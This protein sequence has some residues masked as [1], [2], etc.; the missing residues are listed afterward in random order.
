MQHK[1]LWYKQ[2][3]CRTHFLGT[4]TKRPLLTSVGTFQIEL[5][6]DALVFKKRGNRSTKR[7][8]HGGKKVQVLQCSHH[9]VKF[10][11]PCH[12]Y[13]YLEITSLLGRQRWNKF[14]FT[15]F[16]SH[17]VEPQT[18]NFRAIF[19]SCWEML[20]FFQSSCLFRFLIQSTPSKTDT[21]GTGS[22]CPS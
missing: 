21:F 14:K 20:I 11:N 13:Q 15:P 8:P 18:E 9:F 2:N 10:C 17:I 5:E 12:E 1:P 19:W 16:L 6:F 3:V 7:K 22:K 4:K